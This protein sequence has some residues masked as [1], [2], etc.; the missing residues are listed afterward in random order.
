MVVYSAVEPLHGQEDL[1]PT[2]TERPG[3]EEGELQPAS[4]CFAE[5]FSK[6]QIVDTCQG[7]TS[8]VLSES[9][10]EAVSLK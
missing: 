1:Y 9:L 7:V 3:V 6:T 2:K 5:N 10:P 8:A 4:L